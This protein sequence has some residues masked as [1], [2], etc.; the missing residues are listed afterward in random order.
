[1][2]LC[3]EFDFV[4]FADTV[5]QVG[6]L[7]AEFFADLY[8]CGGC[9][10]YDI[11]QQRSHQSLRVHMP[12]RENTGDSY[13]MKDISFAALAKLPGVRSLTEIK[14]LSDLMDVLRFEITA[15]LF[16]KLFNFRHVMGLLAATSSRELI[17][18]SEL[19]VSLVEHFHAHFTERNFAQCD[20]GGL[21]LSAVHQRRGA[22]SQLPRAIS[23]CEG[24]F[25]AVGNLLDAIVYRNACH[26][27]S[28]RL[29]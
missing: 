15:K 19:R 21:I 14:C 9:V 8:F 1:M 26:K 12:L 18:K 4:E 7:L 2:D 22:H 27:N 24:Q 10:F 28:L 20:H 25:E 17:V 11:M 29:D 16:G 5:D 23:R 13:R 3:L 6:H